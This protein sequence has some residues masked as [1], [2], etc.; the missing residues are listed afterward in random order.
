[1][2]K[3]FGPTLLIGG[4]VGAC[5]AALVVLARDFEAGSGPGVIWLVTLA[6]PMLLICLGATWSG[7]AVPLAMRLAAVALGCTIA[8]A[9][10]AYACGLLGPAPTRYATDGSACKATPV[11]PRSA[12]NSPHGPPR[13]G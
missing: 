11:L 6:L 5:A 10:V 8:A 4:L 2:H 13:S 7:A 1:M 3:A 12:P 9:T